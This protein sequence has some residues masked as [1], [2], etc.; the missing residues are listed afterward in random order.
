MA[1]RVLR[2]TAWV[3]FFALCMGVS[4][5]AGWYLS[6]WRYTDLTYYPLV[7]KVNRIEYSPEDTERYREDLANMRQQGPVARGLWGPAS[8]FMD[9]PTL[10][11]TVDHNRPY[12]VYKCEVTLTDLSDSNYHHGGFSVVSPG[13]AAFVNDNYFGG[14]Y[15]DVPP[16]GSATG[17]LYLMAPTEGLTDAEVKAM[18][19]KIYITASLGVHPGVPGEICYTIFP[20]GDATFVG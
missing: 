3:L 6:K 7:G 18:F 11:E 5:G 14:A 10:L 15:T 2:A 19:Q 13:I 8:P 16:N 12:R 20:L 17:T 4:F 9:T 1:K